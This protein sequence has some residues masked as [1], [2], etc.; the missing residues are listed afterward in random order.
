MS[1]TTNQASGLFYPGKRI[2]G[3]TIGIAIMDRR[4]P[5]PP[6]DMGNAQSFPFPVIYDVV[7]GVNNMPALSVSQ[8]HNLYQPLYESCMRLVEQGVA[9]ITTTCG[10][11]ALLQQRLA[12]TLPVLFAASSLVQIPSVLAALGANK[13]IA[14]LAARGGGLAHEHLLNTG[15]R[16]DQLERVQIVDLQRSPAFKAAILDA[17]G[18]APLDLPAATRE[19]AELCRAAA[20]ADPLLAG[21]VAECSNTSQYSAAIQNLTGLPVWDSVGL[22]RWLHGAAS[23]VGGPMLQAGQ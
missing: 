17:P 22:T 12:D 23:S 15:V 3:V 14:V 2:Y 4:F 1:L 6:G 21:F 5:R 19:I 11:A 9:A 20:E 18:E 13:K 8:T 7:H 10:Y 16:E